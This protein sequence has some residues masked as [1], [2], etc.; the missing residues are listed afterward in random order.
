[1]N[2]SSSIEYLHVNYIIY[3]DIKAEN[4]LFSKR[5]RAK[6]CDFRYSI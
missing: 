2:I 1:M 5:R 4:I 6:I 3:L